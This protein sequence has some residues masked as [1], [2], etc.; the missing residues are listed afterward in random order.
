MNNE[1]TVDEMTDDELNDVLRR[2][3]EYNSESIKAVKEELARRSTANE[4]HSTSGGG[5]YG[6]PV[7]RPD[8]AHEQ[9]LAS[10]I[11]A[12]SITAINISFGNVLCIMFKV[13]IAG[14]FLSSLGVVFF[15]IFMALFGGLISDAIGMNL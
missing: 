13:M 12:V 3:K 9:N 4:Q 7:G 5:V 15:L 6:S 8:T 14:F 2:A 11:T 10:A 1:K